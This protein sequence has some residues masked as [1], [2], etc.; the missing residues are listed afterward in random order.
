MFINILYQFAFLDKINAMNNL[1]LDR[2][3]RIRAMWC[4]LSGLG[5]LVQIINFGIIYIMSILV[6]DNSNNNIRNLVYILIQISSSLS[7]FPFVLPLIFWLLNRKMHPFVDRAGKDTIN[8]TIGVFCQL[9]IFSIIVIFISLVVCGKSPHDSTLLGTLLLLGTIGLA[10]IFITNIAT[11]IYAAIRA[12]K[13]E[14]YNYP[15]AVKVF[16]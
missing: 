14:V 12:S 8:Y 7:S 5:I 11:S 15:F 16:R 13:G 2:S 6:S 3:I 10:A 9:I 4:H 1:Q